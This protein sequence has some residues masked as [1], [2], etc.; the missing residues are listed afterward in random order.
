MFSNIILYNISFKV[1]CKFEI[2]SFEVSRTKHNT[3]KLNRTAHLRT[4]RDRNIAR[5]QYKRTTI[6]NY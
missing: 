2:V 4:S 5:K 6:R 1:L 3:D